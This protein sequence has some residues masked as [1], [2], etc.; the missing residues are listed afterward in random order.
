MDAAS[1][2]PL[3]RKAL[4]GVPGAK[5]SFTRGAASLSSSAL[6][7]DDIS[8]RTFVLIERA[9]FPTR[10]GL[11]FSRSSSRIT[12]PDSTM[13]MVSRP[14][15]PHAWSFNA[16]PCISTF[17]SGKTNREDWSAIRPMY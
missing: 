2:E 9:A 10:P 6:S 16:R 13:S 8:S 11:F 4:F 7:V 12:G 1:K 17:V 14:S 15:S 3:K 5:Q